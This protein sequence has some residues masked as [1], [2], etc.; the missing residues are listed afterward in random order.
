[1]ESVELEIVKIKLFITMFEID[2]SV[3]VNVDRYVLIK[4]V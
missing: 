4:Y 1:M 3:M 2:R